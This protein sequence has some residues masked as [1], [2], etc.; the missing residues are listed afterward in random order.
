MIG[1]EKLVTNFPLLHY[2]GRSV[3][4]GMSSTYVK[5]AKLT[6]NEQSVFSAN[7]SGIINAL[8]PGN[9]AERELSTLG[10][11]GAADNRKARSF[12]SMAN[13][14]KFGPPKTTVEGYFRLALFFRSRRGFV[15]NL[16]S[17]KTLTDNG[18]SIRSAGRE[19]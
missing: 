11:Q 8:L 10:W 6:R 1:P 14:G 4:T 19:G 18:H 5:T 15:C 13:V 2:A 7:P 9:G 12:P 16:Q 17:N 3:G